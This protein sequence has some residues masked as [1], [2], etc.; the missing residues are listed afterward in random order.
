MHAIRAVV[1]GL[2]GLGTVAMAD[3][4]TLT[5]V[6]GSVL[7][8][9]PGASAWVRLRVQGTGRFHVAINAATNGFNEYLV[10]TPGGLGCAQLPPL[11]SHNGHGEGDFDL[12]P[13]SG[14]L[15]CAYLIQRSLTS[16]SDLDLSFH[17]YDSNVQPA[18]EVHFILG[19]VPEVNF[20]TRQESF[21]LLPD[22]RARGRVRIGSVNRSQVSIVGLSA[23][24]C[25]DLPLNLFNSTLN[26]NIPGGCGDFDLFSDLC[27]DEIPTFIFNLPQ[28]AA[29]STSSC[30]IELTS[31]GTFAHRLSYPIEMG[32]GGMRNMQTNGILYPAFRPA[33]RA[34]SLVADPP[35]FDDE[36]E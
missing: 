15:E 4:V 22:G 21:E 10:A 33:I 23:A 30:L 18:S 24:Y 16:T 34:L 26:G 8:L 12:M 28:V 14:S 6:D 31:I 35:L 3:Q 36:F 1:L 19:T 7:R 17:T 20:W 29:N 9:M 11:N 2:L 27:P 32:T 13:G 5:A 25:L